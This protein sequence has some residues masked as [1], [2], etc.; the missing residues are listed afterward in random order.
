M[1]PILDKLD[2]GTLLATPTGPLTGPEAQ[3]F[4]SDL[5][6]FLVT[7]QQLIIDLSQVLYVGSDG[8]G[9]LLWAHRE[10]GGRLIVCG[11]TPPVCAQFELLRIRNVLSVVLS[12]EQALALVAA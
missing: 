1:Y 6:A 7:T 2:N 3:V 8:C 12:R 5:A 9:V 10:R 4:K 11:V